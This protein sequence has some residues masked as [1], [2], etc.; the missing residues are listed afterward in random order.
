[1]GRSGDCR[2]HWDGREGIH[3]RD[4]EIGSAES[5]SSMSSRS[6]ASTS[7]IVIKLGTI[8]LSFSKAATKLMYGFCVLVSCGGGGGDDDGGDDGGDHCRD[9]FDRP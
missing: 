6:R 7:T 5:P 4:F 2:H 3:G 8:S 9:I 1:M